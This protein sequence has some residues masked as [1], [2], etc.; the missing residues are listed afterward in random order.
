MISQQKYKFVSDNP[1]MK[2]YKRPLTKSKLR[3]IVNLNLHSNSK[4]ILICI[5]VDSYASILIL[6]SKLICY[7]QIQIL[8]MEPYWEI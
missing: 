4:K 6:N 1:S 5:L 8:T 3:R 2:K 7:L